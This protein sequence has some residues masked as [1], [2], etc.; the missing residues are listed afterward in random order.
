MLYLELDD[1]RSRR[2]TGSGSRPTSHRGA[3]A[4]CLTCRRM[5][6][7]AVRLCDTVGA[8]ARS[9]G[10]TS[11]YAFNRALTKDRHIPPG[12]CRTC[13]RATQPPTRPGQGRRKG[14]VGQRQVQPPST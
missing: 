8:V 9:L 7:A 14:H 10:Y 2:R 4:A 6:L 1:R 11:E 3:T 12:R 13:S 5:E